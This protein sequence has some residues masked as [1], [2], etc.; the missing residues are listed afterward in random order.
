M[1]P[2]T[3][4]AA[5]QGPKKEKLKVEVFA[6]R[7]RKPKKFNW[8]PEMLVGEAAREAAEKFEYAAGNPGLSKHNEVL[9]N[10]AT[11]A[12][13]GVED[14]DELTLTDVGGGV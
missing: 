13:A 1:T 5:K 3:E 4:A 9:D 2:E 6:P 8:D 11:L 14:G 12:A 10:N 7:K